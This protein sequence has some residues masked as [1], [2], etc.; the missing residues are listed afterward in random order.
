MTLNDLEWCNSPY[1]AYF[2]E[3]DCFTGQICHSGLILT[4]N[5]RKYFY[6]FCSFRIYNYLITSVSG[7]VLVIVEYAS[8]GN[9]REFLRQRMPLDMIQPVLHESIFCDEQQIILTYKSLVSFAYQ[10]ARGMEYLAS[11]KVLNRF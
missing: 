8:Y 4:Y 10:V 6:E 9:L 1:F 5:V 3:F 2:T 11:K 7:P